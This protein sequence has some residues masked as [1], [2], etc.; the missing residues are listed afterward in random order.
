M[1]PLPINDHVRNFYDAINARDFGILKNCVTKNWVDRGATH[2]QGLDDFILVVK[3]V[4][5]AF[6]DFK[7]VEEARID[8]LEHTVMRL[9]LLGTQNGD[10][11]G[12]KASGKSMDIR[13]HD[14]H[15]IEN[16]HI[17]ESWQIEDWFAGLEQICGNPNGDYKDASS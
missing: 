13:S 14:I 15:R 4:I 11:L 1:N 16:G 7:I 9:R 5:A 3:S 2:D 8:S 6:P 17:A 12:V 10:F